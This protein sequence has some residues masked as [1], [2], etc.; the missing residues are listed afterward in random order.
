MRNVTLEVFKRMI[1]A[2]ATS[3]FTWVVE[4]YCCANEIKFTNVDEFLHSLL[5]VDDAREIMQSYYISS[6]LPALMSS[7]ESTGAPVSTTL[8]FEDCYSVLPMGIWDDSSDVE[9]SL[10]SSAATVIPA[11][12]DARSDDE[13]T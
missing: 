11:A 7:V 8:S 2:K 12:T 4:E 5:S 1:K 9:G 3:G 10:T 6:P 13:A